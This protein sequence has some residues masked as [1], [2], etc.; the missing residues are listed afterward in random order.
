[1]G[2]QIELRRRLFQAKAWITGQKPARHHVVGRPVTDS[3]TI[4]RPPR[5]QKQPE[6]CASP[7]SRRTTARSGPRLIPNLQLQISHWSLRTREPFIGFRPA[8][9]GRA[10]DDPRLIDVVLEGFEAKRD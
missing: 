9:K 5:K 2:P 6:K 7:G 10:A 1:V 8:R 3:T 4:N